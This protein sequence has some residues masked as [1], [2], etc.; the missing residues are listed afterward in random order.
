VVDQ[1]AR[2]ISTFFYVGDFPVAPG[3][4]ATFVGLLLALA[5]MGSPILYIVVFIVIT[6]LGLALSG[7]VE[8]ILGRKDPGCVV[9]DE[10]SGI[11]LAVFLLPPSLPVLVTAFFLFRAFDMFKIWPANQFEAMGGGLGIMADDLAAG[12]WT[13]LT[14]HAALF[15][16]GMVVS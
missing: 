7:R 1:F 4:V 10:V 9:I 6:V 13:S 3:T 14:M 2:M 16:S 8:K 12:L 15:L 11:L 5:L